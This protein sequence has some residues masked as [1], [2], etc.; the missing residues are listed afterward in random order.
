VRLPSLKEDIATW[1]KPVQ[2]IFEYAESH[3][4]TIIHAGRNVLISP[5]QM[6]VATGVKLVADNAIEAHVISTK[7]S[8]DQVAK[9]IIATP[10]DILSY[11]AVQGFKL[12]ASFSR[13]KSW[14]YA[15][16]IQ[17]HLETN[18]TPRA[19]VAAFLSSGGA[20][21]SAWILAR[22]SNDTIL[23]NTTVS[24]SLC[25][26]FNTKFLHIFNRPDDEIIECP[27][28]HSLENQSAKITLQHVLSCPK[29]ANLTR[30]HDGCLRNIQAMFNSCAIPV[31]RE[32][33]TLTNSLL[34]PDMVVPAGIISKKQYIL[35]VAYVNERAKSYTRDKNFKV[36]G[37]AARLRATEKTGKYAASINPKTQIFQPIICETSGTM[38]KEGLPKLIEFLAAK[39]SPV[40][41][42]KGEDDTPKFTTYWFSRFS[43]WLQICNANAVTRAV[44]EA[45]QQGRVREFPFTLRDVQEV[46]ASDEDQEDNCSDDEDDAVVPNVVA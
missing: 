44:T 25:N 18:N 31:R 42:F 8:P 22:P 28:H 24:V 27:C 39:F 13:D 32:V 20:H 1:M 15:S 21:A 40:A 35:E 6:D 43:I 37:N 46:P 5:F 23:D 16:E 45:I 26:R 38:N 30:K 3:Q 10:M 41:H 14:I 34:R 2:E 29:H 33:R 9:G 36:A 11:N 12:Q 7:L 19:T 4:Q 17:K